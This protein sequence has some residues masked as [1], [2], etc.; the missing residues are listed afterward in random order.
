MKLRHLLL[1]TGLLPS[2]SLAGLDTG[3]VHLHGSMKLNNAKIISGG[4]AV[5]GALP[6][7]LLRP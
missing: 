1:L 5:Y 2:L 4:K 3:R 7:N 6:H